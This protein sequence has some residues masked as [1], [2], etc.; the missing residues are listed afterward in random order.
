M[1][2]LRLIGLL[3]AGSL[4]FFTLGCPDDDPDEAQYSVELAGEN[5]TPLVATPATGEMNVNLE[6]N[7]LRVEGSFEGL[8]SRLVEIEGSPAHIHLGFEDEAGPVIYNVDVSAD[9]DERSGVFEFDEMLTDDEVSA[10]FDEELYLNIHTN[11]YPGGELRGQFDEDAPEFAGIDES[12]G[13]SL[14]DEVQ[15]HDVETDAEGWAWVIL[16]DDNTFVVSGAVSDLSDDLMEVDGSA[17]NIEEAATGETG[18]IVFNLNY[19]AREDNEARFWFETELSDEQV[20]TLM[21]GNYYINI[22]TDEFED[23]ELRAQI[24]DDDNFFEDFWEDI[25]GDDDDRIDEAPPF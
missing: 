23:G 16:R 14:T 24:D 8:V 4:V 21:D 3:A 5:Q 7:H 6:D 9:D 10:F 1:K 18:D 2:H 15:P 22:Y 20:D 17:V 19:E 13:L 25:F 12:W 11:A